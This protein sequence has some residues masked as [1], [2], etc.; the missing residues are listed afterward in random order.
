MVECLLLHAIW[1]YD[2][3]TEK[4]RPGIA[5]PYC[6]GGHRE[7]CFSVRVAAHY[8]FMIAACSIISF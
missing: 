6:K 2:G 3:A 1:W 8:N 7:T 4:A 5:A